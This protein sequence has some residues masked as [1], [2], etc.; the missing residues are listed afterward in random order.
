MA[1]MNVDESI[2]SWR[3]ELLGFLEKMYQFRELAGNPR[4]VL[5]QLSAYSIRARYMA[6]V[7]SQHD[8]RKLRDFKFE[9]VIPFLQEAEFQRQTWSRIGTLIKDEWDMAKG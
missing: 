5:M 7:C 2:S 6:A 1:T 9:E 8:N 4:E 3:A